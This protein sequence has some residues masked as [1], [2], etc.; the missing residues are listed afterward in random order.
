MQQVDPIIP[1]TLGQ[2]PTDQDSASTKDSSLESADANSNKPHNKKFKDRR[3]MGMQ[4]PPVEFL[5][6]VTH[7]RYKDYEISN[8]KEDPVDKQNATAANYERSEL[9]EDSSFIFKANL[10]SKESISQESK[11][12]RNTRRN[13]WK[14]LNNGENLNHKNKSKESPAKE[15]SRQSNLFRN[16]DEKSSKVSKRHDENIVTRK[17]SARKRSQEVWDDSREKDTTGGPLNYGGSFHSGRWGMSISSPPTEFLKKRS[18]RRK[19]EEHIKGE[20]DEKHN[21]TSGRWGMSVL[22]PPKEFLEDIL[23]HRAH[24]SGHSTVKTRPRSNQ[25][26]ESS[27]DHRSLTQQSR[28]NLQADSTH[29]SIIDERNKELAKTLYEKILNELHPAQHSKFDAYWNHYQTNFNINRPLPKG[30]KFLMKALRSYV[31]EN[32]I[33]IPIFCRIQIPYAPFRI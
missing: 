19:N 26:K 18:M 21:F 1:M 12:H 29:R 23:M 27:S 2:S 3:N 6:K 22:S 8:I 15:Y 4:N 13:F 9:E 31:E 11:A 14:N 16:E 32:D 24:G 33:D 5:S 7:Q 28:Q 25:V 20:K 17:P 10:Q 30:I